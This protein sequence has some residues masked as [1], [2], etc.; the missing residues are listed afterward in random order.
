[1][2]ELDGAN[3]AEVGGKAGGDE[4]NCIVESERAAIAPIPQASEQTATG[5]GTESVIK[6]VTQDRPDNDSDSDDSDDLGLVNPAPHTTVIVSSSVA[7]SNSISN[8][9]SPT[10]L[11]STEQDQLQQKNSELPS[12]ENKVNSHLP[13]TPSQAQKTSTT[14]QDQTSVLGGPSIDKISDVTDDSTMKIS[15]TDVSRAPVTTHSSSVTSTSTSIVAKEATPAANVATVV[16]PT[17]STTTTLNNSVSQQSVQ[18]DTSSPQSI[19]SQNEPAKVVTKSFFFYYLFLF[20]IL[21]TSLIY[22]LFIFTLTTHQKKAVV[23]LTPLQVVARVSMIFVPYILLSVYIFVNG[24]SAIT[25]TT[26]KT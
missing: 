12:V 8:S 20:F 23:F 15:Q 10:P 19:P 9:P 5:E 1:M 4:G 24:V 2:S 3:S 18:N 26:T 13:I 21:N 17:S 16:E 7:K 22:H 6:E 25:L 14:G 11:A